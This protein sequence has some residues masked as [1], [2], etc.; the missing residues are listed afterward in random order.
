VLF[1][2][3]DWRFKFVVDAVDLDDFAQHD[4]GNVEALPNELL[5]RDHLDVDGGRRPVRTLH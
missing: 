3:I 2:L 1:Y 4:G 5:G